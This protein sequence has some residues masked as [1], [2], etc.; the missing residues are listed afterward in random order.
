MDP[1]F[2]KALT[3]TL[4]WEG[5]F[6]NVLG[7][8]GKAT[9]YGISLP[10]AQSVGLDKDGDGDVDEEDIKLLTVEDAVA[11]YE[12]DFWYGFKCDTYP[13]PY[14]IA[15]FD[16]CV[17]H[18]PA[19]VD[20]IQDEAKGDWKKLIQARKAYAMAWINRK[21][22]ER[23]KFQKGFLNRYNDLRKLCEILEHS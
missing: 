6:A 8:P 5:G 20:L 9:K 19:A 1:N 11:K 18:S 17:Q 16:T 14:S 4:K 7:D 15:L 21:P 23:S 12:R 13:V 2:Q 3:F 22:K 10:Y